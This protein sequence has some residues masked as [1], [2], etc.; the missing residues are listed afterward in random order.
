MIFDNL[1]I[2]QFVPEFNATIPFTQ[3]AEEIIQ[4]Y[5]GDSSRQIVDE[6]FNQICDRIIAAYQ[7]AWSDIK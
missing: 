7:K 5:D 2:K 4:W 3:G 6:N 1:K